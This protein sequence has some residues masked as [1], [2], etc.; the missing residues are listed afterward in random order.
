MKMLNWK[1]PQANIIDIVPHLGFLFP[2]TL[3]STFVNS[4]YC[5][6]W[7]NQILKRLANLINGCDNSTYI[8]A[9]VSIVHQNIQSPILLSLDLLK[10]VENVVVILVVALYRHT[11]AA[12]ISDLS[13]FIGLYSI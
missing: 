3:R 4:L 11:N 1:L 8:N 5:S 10:Q 2:E 9:L 6:I 12:S 13:W 7:Q